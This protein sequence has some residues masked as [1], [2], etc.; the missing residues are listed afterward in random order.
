V[1]PFYTVRLPIILKGQGQD[2]K[3]AAALVN[4]AGA[5]GPVISQWL[6]QGK[7]LPENV[8]EGLR[9][10]EIGQIASSMMMLVAVFAG[11][12]AQVHAFVLVA[13]T[14]ATNLFTVFFNSLAQQKLPGDMRGRF[15][16]N[17]MSLANL[18]GAAGALIVGIE[19]ESVLVVILLL[20][21]VARVI[22]YKIRMNQMLKQS[23]SL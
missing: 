7:F 9:V 8:S 2:W 13:S 23:N 19:S 22:L 17:L 5:I 14:T 18:A 16:A 21:T 20:A 4:A 12:G 11:V 1:Y 3:E 10:A 15:L 6:V